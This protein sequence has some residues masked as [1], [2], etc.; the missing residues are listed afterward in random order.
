M[1]FKILC[2]IGKQSYKK[3]QNY[4]Y[5][6]KLCT[7]QQQSNDVMSN[8]EKKVINFKSRLGGSSWLCYPVTPEYDPRTR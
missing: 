3:G 6:Y 2:G 7:I 1:F 5:I 8:Q 4:K